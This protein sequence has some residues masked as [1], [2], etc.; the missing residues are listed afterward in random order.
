MISSTS[1]NVFHVFFSESKA[2]CICNNAQIKNGCLLGQPTE[3]AIVAVGLKVG[4]ISSKC[5]LFHH[6]IALHVISCS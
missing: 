1:G 2:G 6:N 3:G 4:F 5:H